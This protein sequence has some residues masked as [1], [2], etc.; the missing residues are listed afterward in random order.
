MT[1]SLYAVQHVKRLRGGAQAHLLRGSDGAFHVSKLK[2]NPQGI[3]VLANEMFATQL[4]RFVGLPMPQVDL[5]E[6]SEWLIQHT[7][8]LCIQLPD[9]YRPCSSV[10]D[11]Q[12]F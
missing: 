8:E 9:G 11:D 12:H 5:I 2:E 1:S 4:G 3:R 7:P 10:V 6:I